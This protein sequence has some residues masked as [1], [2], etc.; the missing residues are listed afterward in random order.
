MPQ[1]TDGLDQSSSIQGGQEESKVQT[2]GTA[3]NV[4]KYSA[5]ENHIDRSDYLMS[6]RKTWVDGF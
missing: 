3:K 2:Q 1:I 6:G 4:K 5:I